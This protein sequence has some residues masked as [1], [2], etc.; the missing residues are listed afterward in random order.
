MSLRCHPNAKPVLV[1]G[2]FLC[3]LP[4][5]LADGPDR[6]R[7]RTVVVSAPREVATFN[8]TSISDED[9]RKAAA[10][11]LDNLSMQ[12][13]EMNANVAR[14][15]H[16]ILETTLLRLLADKMF[17]AEAAKRGTSKDAFLDKELQGKVKEPSIQ[18]ITS[19]YEANKQRFNQPLDKVADQIQQY[20]KAQNRIKAIG[21]LADNLKAEYGVKV[22]LPPLRVKVAT[23]GSP[24]RGPKEAPV[25]IVEFSDFQCPYCAQLSRTL[26]EA[27]SKY[28]DRV[29]LVYKQFPL[30][31]IHPFAEK[32]AEAA[33]CAGDQDKFWDL[34]D[35]MFD[36]QNELKEE[37]LKAKGAQLK[38]DSTA[39]NECLTSGKEANRV[40]QDQR[41][42]YSLGVSTTPSFFVNGRFYS[43]AIPLADLS[44]AIDEEIALSSTRASAS[45]ATSSNTHA[46]LV[47]R[48]P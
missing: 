13:D 29:R 37:D 6:G 39:F 48:K 45:A 11:D 2:L 47:A 46:A 21:D 20:L 7:A 32:A 36:K 5:L 18:D 3:S 40:K 22:L 26:H 9:L 24:S 44:K 43:G 17:E 1:L 38:F 25:T 35:L 30:S 31:Q 19:F 28:G 14:M 23:D 41:E 16:Q 8:G 27:M 10:S 34:H 12:V 42:G 4:S 33:L 15:E